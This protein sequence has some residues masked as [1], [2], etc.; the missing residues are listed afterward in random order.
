M[1]T[2]EAERQFVR[3]LVAEEYGAGLDTWP[4]A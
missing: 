1:L 4:D 3:D 2:L